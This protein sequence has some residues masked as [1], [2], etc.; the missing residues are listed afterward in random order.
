MKKVL[1]LIHTLQAGGAE[2]VL[3]D[4]V[5]ALDKNK[6]DITV[7]TVCDFGD[8]KYQLNKNIKY[9]SIFKFKF[10]KKITGNKKYGQTINTSTKKNLLKE[11]LINCYKSFWRIANLDKFYRKH[12]KEEYDIEV[13]FLEGIPAKIISHSSN[14]KS[15]KVVWLH[16]D[17][18]NENKSECF[19]TSVDEQK[20]VYRAFD[21]IVCVSGV[22]KESFC[23]KYDFDGNRVKVIYN[24]INEKTIQ[25]KSVEEITDLT[26]TNFTFCTVGRL[27][28]Q[29]GYDRLLRAVKRLNDDNLACDI[30]IIGVGVLEGELKKRSDDTFTAVLDEYR[31]NSHIFLTKET[32]RITNLSTF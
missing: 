13:A 9:R 14:P 20:Q 10:L 23:K 29:K 4:L 21:E 2:K 5:N 25:K 31:K 24:P 18:I 3:V 32:R 17:L 28:K 6:F 19:F 27:A 8:L 26:K 22:V 16:V 7:M 12:I 30:W 15:K 1:F 11:F